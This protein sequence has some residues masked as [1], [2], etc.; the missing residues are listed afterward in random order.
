VNCHTPVTSAPG[1]RLV[2]Q[3]SPG[4]RFIL[5]YHV[6]V[7]SRHSTNNTRAM[8]SNKHINS[9]NP[10]SYHVSHPIPIKT[11]LIIRH[12]GYNATNSSNA[13]LPFP[14]QATKRPLLFR[15]PSKLQKKPNITNTGRGERKRK[16][17]G[18][19]QKRTAPLCRNAMLNNTYINPGP[20]APTIFLTR[21][22]T[23]WHYRA[24]G[25][26]VLALSP[27]GVGVCRSGSTSWAGSARDSS[28]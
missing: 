7:K 26:G 3:D 19:R 28:L 15:F 1:V 13:M 21:V 14:S 25:T 17:K 6:H 9:I 22:S 20:S 27:R 8:K 11:K 5:P 10:Q 2:I 18:R 24:P 4:I 16:R 12:G 23:C